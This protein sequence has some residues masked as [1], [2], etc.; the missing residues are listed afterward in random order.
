MGDGTIYET[1]TCISVLAELMRLYT[2]IYRTRIGPLL[3]ELKR[4]FLNYTFSGCLP[5]FAEEVGDASRSKTVLY[6]GELLCLEDKEL[7]G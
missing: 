4:D 2:H 3:K 6:L 1:S 7:Q 5:V